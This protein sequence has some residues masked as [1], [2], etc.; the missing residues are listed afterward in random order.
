MNSIARIC[1][2]LTI[3]ELVFFL[4]S[5]L[6]PS[7]SKRKKLVNRFEQQLTDQFFN[8]PVVTFSRA[9]VGFYYLLSEL[10]LTPGCEVIITGL[11]VPDFV[12]MINLA[13]FKPV[14]VDIDVKTFNI[15]FED[16]QR[17]ITDKTG[18]ILV[19]H[20]Y[21]YAT[22]MDRLLAITEKYE[23]PL[24]ED[25]SQAWQTLYRGKPL[26]TFGRAAIYSL[27]RKKHI[28]T[29][30]GGLVVSEDEKLMRKLKKSQTRLPDIA[31][32]ELLLHGLFSL[33]IKIATTKIL[34]SSLF[35]PLL[36]LK[37]SGKVTGL[38]KKAEL[39]KKLPTNYRACFTW[40]QAW[41]GLRQLSRLSSN[42]RVV[43]I[44]GQELY[45]SIR[46]IPGIILPDIQYS[47]KYCPWFFPVLTEQPALFQ[48]ILVRNNIDAGRVGLQSMG[49]IDCFKQFSFRSESA[50]I[51]KEK[52]I[53]VPVYPAMTKSDLLSMIAAFEEFG[54]EIH[55][56]MKQERT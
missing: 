29:L 34:F 25:C 6:L 26:G 38:K 8:R 36:G 13:G 11:H 12:N 20:L 23:I 28:S 46:D 1:I 37:W 45:A 30:I 15:D 40:Q 17:K 32:K 41:L 47:Q 54:R 19:S 31:K 9:R 52:T 51:V 22:D 39:F 10:G 18:L 7:N 44:H 43:G 50:S 21:G 56:E 2:P 14:V 16:L 3:K 48:K 24:V 33:I 27:S 5:L 49:E 53:L 35:M 55:S 4:F 42:V